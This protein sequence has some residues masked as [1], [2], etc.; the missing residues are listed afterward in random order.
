MAEQRL[1]LREACENLERYLAKHLPAFEIVDVRRR[2][3]HLHSGYP[4]A[5]VGHNRLDGTYAI[6]EAYDAEDDLRGGRYWLPDLETSRELLQ[7][8]L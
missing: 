3:N 8:A 7:A 6:W 2:I 5:V 4:Y 1:N